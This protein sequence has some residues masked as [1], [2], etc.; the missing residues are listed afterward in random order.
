M[1]I[2]FLHGY[3]SQPGGVKPT[4]L[5]QHGHEVLNPALLSEDFEASV[6]IAQQAFDEGE[7]EVVVGSSRGGAVAMSIDTGDV[8]LVLIA[9]AWKRW[10]AATTVKAA[11]TILHSEHDEQLHLPV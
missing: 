7:P 4:F 9:P 2:L 5:R 11:V 8:P 10:G 1:R 6:R 3:Q